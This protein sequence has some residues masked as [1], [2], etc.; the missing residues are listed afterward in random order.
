MIQ[1][2]DIAEKLCIQIFRH[3]PGIHISF[4][5]EGVKRI[6]SP[7]IDESKTIKDQRC[8]GY[9]KKIIDQVSIIPDFI[10]ERRDGMDVKTLFYIKIEF[11]DC[12]NEKIK[13]NKEALQKL[14][15]YYP[16]TQL[17]IMTPYNSVFYGVDIGHIDNG[18]ILNLE[19]FTIERLFDGLYTDDVLPVLKNYRHLIKDLFRT[20]DW[21][22][23]KIPKK[24]E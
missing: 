19:N 14:K 17:F 12:P 20:I 6:F 9:I 22:D 4:F 3:I 7:L 11:L 5:G 15:R 23:N 13:F 24:I 8:K 1:E 16:N 21:E 10:V 18:E 2:K